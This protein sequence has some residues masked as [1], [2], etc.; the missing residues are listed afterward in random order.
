MKFFFTL[1]FFVYPHTALQC[2]LYKKVRD[3][4]N[5]RKIFFILIKSLKKKENLQSF[6]VLKIFYVTFNQIKK[7]RPKKIIKKD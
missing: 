7:K 1:V 6:F 4:N 2:L 3:L 5:L